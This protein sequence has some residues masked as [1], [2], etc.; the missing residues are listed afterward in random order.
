MHRVSA[1]AERE[2]E[3]EGEEEKQS[4]RQ[5]NNV[6]STFASRVGQ[7]AEMAVFD[8]EELMQVNGIASHRTGRRTMHGPAIDAEIA[9]HFLCASLCA[10]L[11]VRLPRVHVMRAHCDGPALDVYRK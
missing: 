5:L 8:Y 7:T 9:Q 4:A 6:F 1:R 10:P 3:G 11:R 2:G